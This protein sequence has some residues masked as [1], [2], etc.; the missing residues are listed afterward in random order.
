MASTERQGTLL[1]KIEA[2]YLYSD[3]MLSFFLQGKKKSTVDA[4]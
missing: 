3:S 1:N 4:I 2:T